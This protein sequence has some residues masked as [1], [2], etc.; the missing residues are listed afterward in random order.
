[1]LKQEYL[2][3][4]KKS[5]SPLPRA[6]INERV[7]FYSEMIDDLIEEGLSENE[8]TAKIG[9]IADIS[10]QI[11]TDF[12]PK[13]AKG[14]AKQLNGFDIA[15]MIIGAPVWLPLLVAAAAIVLSFYIIIW[16]LIL[17]VWAVEAPFYIFAFISKYLLI[18]CINVTKCTASF[19]KSSFETLLGL[20][21]RR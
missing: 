17:V 21:K 4:L 12:D 5:L 20:I 15:M 10:R 11:I 6:E 14:G 18:F 1:M 7:N 2:K 13:R 9:S 3:Q 19:T 16:S 8:A